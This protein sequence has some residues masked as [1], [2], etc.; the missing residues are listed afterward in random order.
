MNYK[1]IRL[2]FF[3]RSRRGRLLSCDLTILADPIL[4]SSTPPL[5]SSSNNNFNNN[6]SILQPTPISSSNITPSPFFGLPVQHPVNNNSLIPNTSQVPRG[7]NNLMAKPFTSS[8]FSFGNSSSK[9]SING[10]SNNNNKEM[11]N[12][13]IES[14]IPMEMLNKIPKV[15]EPC[16]QKRL[17]MCHS[18]LIGL[19]CKNGLSLYSMLH[20]GEI[21]RILNGKK[22][23]R[24]MIMMLYEQCFNSLSPTIRNEYEEVNKFLKELYSIE[25]SQRQITQYEKSLYLY[26]YI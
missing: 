23:N 15:T 2:P 25:T 12:R 16:L 21:K 10:I 18:R 6:I 1:T 24:N 26:I 8:S 7:Y 22:R 14:I 4:Y 19:P 9:K 11:N 13:R 3:G 20:K 5:N 17:N